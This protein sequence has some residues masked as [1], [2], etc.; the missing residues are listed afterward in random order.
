MDFKLYAYVGILGL[1]EYKYIMYC[2]TV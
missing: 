1:Q 2:N